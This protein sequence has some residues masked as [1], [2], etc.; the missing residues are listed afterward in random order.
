[1]NK[2]N[3][4]LNWLK[5]PH[6]IALVAIYAATVAA[7]FGAIYVTVACEFAFPLKALSYALYAIAAVLLGY[8]VYTVIKIIPTAKR[9]IIARLKKWEFT[10]M[11]LEQFDFRTLIFAMGSC[12]INF[13][14]ALYNGVLGMVI[15]SWWNI[16]FGAYYLALSLMRGNILFYHY[17]KKK[18][19]IPLEEE[20]KL[21][22]KAYRGNGIMLVLLPVCLSV[23]IGFMARG[24]KSF[25]YFSFTIYI[26]AVYA[27]YKIIMSFV[28]IVR[29]RKL[30]DFSIRGIRSVNVADSLVS[31]LALQTAL[32]ANYSE[33]NGGLYNAVTGGF[34]CVLTIALGVYIIVNATRHL[35]KEA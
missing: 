23:A 15:M 12:V 7:G 29:A 25:H 2:N 16:S 31:I 9:R 5:N 18:R 1:M 13:V 26:A 14:Y 28:N 3:R 10:R 21:E 8:T 33:A 35:K 20:K 6:G 17:R 19:N 22:I 11:L 30:D 32:L 24:E 4:F 34:V 27:F